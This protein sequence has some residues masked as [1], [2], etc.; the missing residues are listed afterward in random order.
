MG[1]RVDLGRNVDAVGAGGRS[2]VPVVVDW[3]V[4][5]RGSRVSVPLLWSVQVEGAKRVR[6]VNS[7]S[8][9]CLCAS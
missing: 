6:Q 8:S 7:D 1:G 4:S 2:V 5:L 9:V 3:L